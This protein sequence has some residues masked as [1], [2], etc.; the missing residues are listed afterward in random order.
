[1]SAL[2]G[3]CRTFSFDSDGSPMVIEASWKAL[4]F[5]GS[6]GVIVTGMMRVF[7]SEDSEDFLS[8]GVPTVAIFPVVVVPSGR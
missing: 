6:S 7:W 5:S 1:M 3:T 2:T 8:V 4:V